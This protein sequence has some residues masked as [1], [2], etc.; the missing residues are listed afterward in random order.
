MSTLRASLL[1]LAAE[2][3]KPKYTGTATKIDPVWYQHAHLDMFEPDKGGPKHPMIGQRVVDYF[4]RAPTSEADFNQMKQQMMKDYAGIRKGQAQPP[5]AQPAAQQPADLGTAAIQARPRPKAVVRPKPAPAPAAPAPAPA[6]VPAPP[7]QAAPAPAP[8]MAAAPAVP[9]PV[10]TP[11]MSTTPMAAPPVAARMAPMTPALRPAVPS[12][13]ALGGAV[14]GA[15]AGRVA[16][17]PKAPV[18]PAPVPG[19]P[20]VASLRSTLVKMAARMDK[21]ASA[22]RAMERLLTA[23]ARQGAERSMWSLFRKPLVPAATAEAPRTAFSEWAAK[24]RA[25]APVQL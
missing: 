10:P 20:K 22:E 1:K 15:A 23:P 2:A 21:S 17:M 25:A 4:G 13:S 12:M 5:A 19:V 18:A 14:P 16:P 3:E 24:K 7:V 9:P 6:P 11:T 8:A